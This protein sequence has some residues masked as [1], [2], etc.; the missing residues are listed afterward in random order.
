[1]AFKYPEQKPLTEEELAALVQRKFDKFIENQRRKG[2][3]LQH[4]SQ[5]LTRELYEY[6][7]KDENM[8]TR[9]EFENCFQRCTLAAD[10]LFTG[11]E[12]RKDPTLEEDD[13]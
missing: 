9:E 1:M 8:R 5:R 10:I 13:T 4:E 7:V 6:F 11:L 3:Q 12:E 2:L